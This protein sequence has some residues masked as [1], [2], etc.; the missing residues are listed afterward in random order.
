MELEPNIPLLRKAV[1]WVEAQ[2]QLPVQTRE[3]RQEDFVAPEHERVNYYG[4]DVGCG[5]AYCVA[6]W[7]AAQVHPEL[8]HRYFARVNGE[9][10]YSDDV[11]MQ[12]LGLDAE[13]AGVLFSPNNSAADVR[14][15]AEWIA[16]ERL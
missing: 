16:G 5:T 10:L 4:H 14:K 6:G 11:A 9:V 2:D 15:T 12:Q 13:Q 3:W 7:V 1:E 8:E